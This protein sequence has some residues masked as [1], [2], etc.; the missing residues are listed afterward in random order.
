MARKRIGVFGGSFDPIH[1]G[2]LAAAAGARHE[3]NL[4][5]VLVVVANLPW[6]KEG[7]R[8]IAD[9][10]LRYA[11]V[12]AAVE[13]HPELVASRIEI[14]RGGPSYTADT[15]AEVARQQPDA[16]LFLIVGMDT[17]AKMQTWNR[18]QEVAEQAELVIVNRPGESPTEFSD[19]WRVLRIEVPGLDVS[20]TDLRERLG[21]GRSVD[22]LIPRAAL[23]LLLAAGLY[24]GYN[25]S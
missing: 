1:V 18:W 16:E 19:A 10:E 2:H 21:D 9:P 7:V 5:E 22:F 12:Q 25:Q 15:L 4:D 13:G 17:A 3:L 11:M 14:D 8:D 20:S 24:P 23:E 6:Q